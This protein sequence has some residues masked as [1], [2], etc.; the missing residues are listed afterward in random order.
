MRARSRRMQYII[1]WGEI[2]RLTYESW[3]TVSPSVLQI[4]FKALNS[5]RYLHREV[6]ENP[7]LGIVHRHC[8]SI[9]PGVQGVANFVE[10]CQQLFKLRRYSERGCRDRGV[11]ENHWDT[12]HEATTHS[13]DYYV[14]KTRRQQHYWPRICHPVIGERPHYMSNQI[15]RI[16]IESLPN[17]DLIQPT[18][19]LTTRKKASLIQEG[20]CRYSTRKHEAKTSINVNTFSQRHHVN[21][22]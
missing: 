2:V 4:N 13:E 5:K 9:G 15:G 18:Y 21:R 6:I 10:I 19:D 7:I 8:P 20:R 11:V 3:V 16:L 14:F 22:R 17:R 1:K 12:P